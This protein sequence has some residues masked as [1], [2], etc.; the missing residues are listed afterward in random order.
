MTNSDFLRGSV[1]GA[2][3]LGC[4][5]AVT[6]HGAGPATVGDCVEAGLTGNPGVR[7]AAYRVDAARAQMRT[8]R[9]AYYPRLTA[10]GSYTRS[11]SP[12]HSFMM[13]LNQRRLDMRDPA[14]DP[15]APEETDNI[16]LSVGL[17]LQLYDG[18]RR[19]LQSDIAEAGA[20]AAEE[21]LMAARN[22]LVHEIRRG[23]YSV[24]QAAAFVNV[25]EESV[26]SLEESLRVARARLEAGSVVKTDV[27][28]L[29]VKLAQAREDLIRARNGAQLAIA[30][31]NTAIGAKVVPPGGLPVPERGG[32]GERPVEPDASR[33][34]QRYELRASRASA[35][36][37]HQAYRSASRGYLPGIGLFGSYDWDGD[38]PGD[39]EDAY[40]VGVKAEWDLFTGGQRPAEI[41]RAR[42]EWRAATEAATRLR[43]ELEFDLKRAHL[44]AVESWERLSVARKSVESAGEALRITRERYEQGAA[45]ITDLLTA[46]LGLTSIRSR[47]VAAYYDH[48]IALSNVERASGALAR[49]HAAPA[50]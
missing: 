29:D 36:A 32:P 33:V 17:G 12:T 15:N 30:A 8:A 42:A 3:L 14:F 50:E 40:L 24:L 38:E 23:Y 21:Q 4:W 45:G 5:W 18:G 34:E 2:L 16:R 9:S 27:L 46:E 35:H 31:L 22:A 37:A 1:R 7:E 28:N 20:F 10:S 13:L 26:A 44:S 11:D 25:H 48:Q 19:G 43:N 39:F 6:A 47:D 41:A 49:R